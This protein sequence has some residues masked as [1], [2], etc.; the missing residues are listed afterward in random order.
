MELGNIQL[1]DCK[2]GYLEI[3]AQQGFLKEFLEF[4][5]RVTPR[6]GSACAGAMRMRKSVVIDDVMSDRE[7]AT[8]REVAYRS[9]RPS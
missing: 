3:K 2:T 1:M 6:E 5:A 4:F 7:F 8:C 9:R